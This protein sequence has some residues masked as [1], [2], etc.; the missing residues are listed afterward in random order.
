MLSGGSAHRSEAA[1]Y[2]RTTRQMLSSANVY[3][4]SL[5]RTVWVRIK[6]HA[7]LPCGAGH[8]AQTNAAW[9]K[10]AACLGSPWNLARFKNARTTL[11]AYN[12][13]R[14]SG[15]SH[16][17]LR[18]RWTTVSG[19]PSSDV[20]LRCNPAGSRVDYAVTTC[21]VG[22]AVWNDVSYCW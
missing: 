21:C 8:A 20:R 5:R 9:L 2:E 12:A 15:F 10:A 3:R 13:L 18:C 7:M 16:A 14:R 11:S 4:I 1:A 19:V 6:C 17:A 22:F